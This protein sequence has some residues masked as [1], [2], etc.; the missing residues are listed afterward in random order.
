MDSRFRGVHARG[1]AAVAARGSRLVLA[2]LG[3]AWAACSMGG[4]GS[5]DETTGT[6]S[7]AVSSGGSAGTGGGTGG[8]GGAGA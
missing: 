6:T 3:L 1:G 7:T 2:F 5:D 8:T 4:C